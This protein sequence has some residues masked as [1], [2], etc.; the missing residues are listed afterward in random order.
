MSK[1]R[2]PDDPINWEPHSRPLTKEELD[3]LEEWDRE[4]EA[5]EDAAA[6]ERRK[7]EGDS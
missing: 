1:P 2:N 7:Q 6:E 3:Q 5:A 4:D